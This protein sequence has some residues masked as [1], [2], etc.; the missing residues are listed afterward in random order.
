MRFG[1]LTRLE[2]EISTTNTPYG[3]PEHVG[4]SMS[5]KS[6]TPGVRLASKDKQTAMLD[7]ALADGETKWTW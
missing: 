6:S 4:L 7:Y 3:Q 5:A 2:Q 1:V